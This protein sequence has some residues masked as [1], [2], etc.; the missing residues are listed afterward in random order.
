MRHVIARLAG[1]A[2]LLMRIAPRW[3]VPQRGDAIRSRYA[4]ML[5]IEPGADAVGAQRIDPIV[6]CNPDECL[7]PAALKEALRIPRFATLT[8]RMHAGKAG[9]LEQLPSADGRV[10]RWDGLR[11]ARYFPAARWLGGA[12]RIVAAAG[13]NTY[14]ESVWLG[15]AARTA[16]TPF[17]RTID[18]QRLR[19]TAAAERPRSNGAD[20]IATAITRG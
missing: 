9:E 11:S 3:F 6:C 18:D 8:V 12:D 5:A 7:S 13:Y 17:A 14:W 16:F 1:E 10:V 15:Y 20:T 2:W 4:R 19:C